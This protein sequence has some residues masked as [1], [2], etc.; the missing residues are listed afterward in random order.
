MN[1][2]E[3]KILCIFGRVLGGKTFSNELQNYLDSCSLN[4]EPYYLNYDDSI[5]KE[6]KLPFWTKFSDAVQAA[7]LIRKKFEKSGA[8]DFNIIVFQGYQLTLAF[9]KTI[10]EKPVGLALD[11]TPYLASKNN[12]RSKK[13][14]KYSVLRYTFSRI[15]NAFFYKSIFNNIDVFL[16]RTDR[17]RSS[18][19]YDYGIS[20]D[21]ILVTYTPSP[22]ITSIGIPKGK[23][24][25]IFVGNDWARKGGD[26]LVELY[27]SGIS[28]FATLSIV[29]NDEVASSKIGNMPIDFYSKLHKAEVLELM[30]RSDI[31]LFPSWKD[32]LGQVLCEAA[33][34]G[35][36]IIARES[37][38]Q[39][40]VVKNNVNGILFDYDSDINDWKLALEKINDDRNMLI[41]MKNESLKL[42]KNKFSDE[43]FQ[44]KISSALEKLFSK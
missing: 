18:L 29:S 37:G 31:L 41:E 36:A 5:F 21:K 27:R 42:A 33:S 7:W 39:S 23:L 20:A 17:V 1:S 32:E 38:A 13:E 6:F 2:K 40:E 14:D 26:F 19:I 43:Y 30:S 9:R 44:E 25:L 24:K 15:L 10:R 12:L 35:L 34:Q 4:V 28:S 8:T 22:S 11:T 16:A 3:K